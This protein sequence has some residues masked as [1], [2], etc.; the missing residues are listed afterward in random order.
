FVTL[1]DYDVHTMWVQEGVDHYFVGTEAMAY[2][3]KAKGIGEAEVT[4]SGIPLVPVFSQ[5]YPSR[6][7]MRR[8]LG[9]DQL[10]PGVFHACRCAGRH[11]N[12]EKKHER[13]QG[14]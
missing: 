4:A 14:F 13:H 11:C 12:K 8:K 6:P 10:Q 2:A 7:D 9:L 3:L 1:T 5:S